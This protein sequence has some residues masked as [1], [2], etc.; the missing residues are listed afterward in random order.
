MKPFRRMFGKKAEV[1]GASEPE[2]A[3]GKNDAAK[4]LPEAIQKTGQQVAGKQQDIQE[5]IAVQGSHLNKLECAMLE[6][7]LG[8]QIDSMHFNMLQR[9]A[10]S[11]LSAVTSKLDAVN[12][13]LLSA[14]GLL[15][16][17]EEVVPLQLQSAA[18]DAIFRQQE[19]QTEVLAAQTAAEQQRQAAAAAA[20]AGP[21]LPAQR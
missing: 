11:Y 15:T 13:A 10:G 17:H 20:A 2:G 3:T 8:N 19:L 16:G 5:E 7:V 12:I 4:T 21:V 18:K 1:V 14:T 9:E 6:H